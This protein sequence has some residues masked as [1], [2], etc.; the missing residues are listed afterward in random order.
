MIN[1]NFIQRQFEGVELVGYVPPLDGGVI[2]SGVTVGAGFDIGQRSIEEIDDAFSYELADKLAPYCGV[3]GNNAITLL[4]EKP[5][6]ITESECE[7]INEYAHKQAE[8]R[9]LAIWQRDC[10]YAFHSLPDGIQTI[11]ASV[12][13][14]YGDLSK[15][16]PNFW[17]QAIEQDWEMMAKN[18][19]DF[20][21]AYP[22]RRRQEY[23][24]L[25]WELTR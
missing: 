18:L 20:G 19:W 14:Q 16:C 4:S 6:V 5:L 9:L 7:I 17:R 1:F 15:A 11:I 21:D 13:F 12:A 2:E 10:D 25:I 3:T 22:T 8:N 24:L 23:I